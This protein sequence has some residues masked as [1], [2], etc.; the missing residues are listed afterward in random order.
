MDKFEMVKEVERLEHE[1][2]H[3]KGTPCEVYSRIVGFYT[4][5]KQWNKG[6]TAEWKERVTF[7]LKET[8]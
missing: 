2:K 5:V 4:P 1:L 3:V 7:D 6:K 8:K